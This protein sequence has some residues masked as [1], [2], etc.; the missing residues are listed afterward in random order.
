[1]KLWVYQDKGGQWRSLNGPV[2]PIDVLWM[3]AA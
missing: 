1:M 3:E 2:L